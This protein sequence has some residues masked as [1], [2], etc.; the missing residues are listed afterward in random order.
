MEVINSLYPRV[1]SLFRLVDDEECVQSIDG[2]GGEGLSSSGDHA[3][4]DGTEESREYRM[5]AAAAA[6]VVGKHHHQHHQQSREHSSH[7]IKLKDCTLSP[8]SEV[9]ES[10]KMY[11]VDDRSALY[12]FVG[13]NVPKVIVEVF[14]LDAST[15][16]SAAGVSA[17]V[18]ASSTLGFGGSSNSNSETASSFALQNEM[19]RKFAL[20]V[21]LL[22]A[23]NPHKQ[24]DDHDDD[25]DDVIKL[26]PL[27]MNT[28]CSDIRYDM[29]MGRS[30]LF[31][32]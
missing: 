18:G 31:F 29:M 13:R 24:G 26:P 15:A 19:G 17:G 3:D 8:S 11:L 2:G 20:F 10:D 6:A 14:L 7:L 28:C 22:K 4:D 27:I 23:G 12:L 5:A 32:S 30:C 21:D 9:F 25:H 16:A 1:Y